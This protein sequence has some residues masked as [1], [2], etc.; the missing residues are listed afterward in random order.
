MIKLLMMASRKVIRNTLLSD[1][2]YFFLPTTI[3][4]PDS[5]QPLKLS[6]AGEPEVDLP[7]SYCLPRFI[8]FYTVQAAYS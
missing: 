3:I 4:I 2:K 7:G 1:V 8:L 6:E 5:P